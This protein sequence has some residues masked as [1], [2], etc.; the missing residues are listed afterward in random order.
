[1]RI[2]ITDAASFLDATLPLRAADPVR[3]NVL[4]AIA[5]GAVAAGLDKYDGA[6]F[7]VA[8]DSAGAPVGAA[9]WTPPYRL[10]LSPME[11]TVAAAVAD[12]AL[13]WGADEGHLMPGVIGPEGTAEIAAAR[14]GR[15][16]AREHDERIL[17]LHDSLPPHHVQGA[18]RPLA[19][20]DIDLFITWTRQFATD[21]ETMVVIDRDSARES[22]RR[23]RFWEVD[24]VPV[25]MAG[26]A[27]IVATPT[28][29]VGRIGPV[30][31]PAEHRGLGYGGAVTAAI[32]EL[33]APQVDVVMLYTDAA[34]LTSNYVYEALGFVHEGDVVE[35]VY[36]SS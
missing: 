14:A 35:L 27:P 36:T 31:T 28:S 8:E 9:L 23:T 26:H 34:N 15:T 25:A 16:F 17:V 5:T 4:G 7:F 24:G 21:A 11:D 18:A 29:T 20:D 19:D 6:A 13:A 22:M 2:R 1:M 10:L 32:V 30:F 33:L 12:A 3:T